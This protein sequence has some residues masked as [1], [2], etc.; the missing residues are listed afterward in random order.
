MSYSQFPAASLR[1]FSLLAIMI[2]GLA[3]CDPAATGPDADAPP[4]PGVMEATRNGPAG[5]APGTCWGKTISPA[6]IETVKTQ[7][8]I[9]PAQVNS[10]GTVGKPPV[11]STEN[12]QE[13]VT[14]RRDNWFE[15]PCPDVLTAE[16]VSS[17]QRAL[18]V[19]GSYAGA[20]TGVMDDATR[21]AILR[22]Q[23]QEGLDSG[24]LS[25][26]TARSLGLVA[27]PRSTTD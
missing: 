3:A 24:V 27:V 18:K 14:P 15:T 17:L 21:E 23:Q 13:I 26:K 10:D 1:R 25:L 2:G 5:A 22:V 4:E 8:Q 20:A 19:R 7:V 9:K 11:Y 6:V 12:R 16:F